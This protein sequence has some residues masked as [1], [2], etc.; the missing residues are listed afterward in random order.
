M[1]EVV[2]PK[3]A[4]SRRKV[5]AK[6]GASSRGHRPGPADT[7]GLPKHRTEWRWIEA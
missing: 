4:S 7:K 3:L 6:P 2:E 5:S 1:A